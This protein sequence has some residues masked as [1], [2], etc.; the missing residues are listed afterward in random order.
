MSPS[1]VGADRAGAADL[2]SELGQRQRRTAGGPRSGD[3]DLLDELAALA[4]R[5]LLDRAHE[6]VENVD[7]HRH[8]PHAPFSSTGFV[9]P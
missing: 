8:D 7:A 3:P 1:R 5:D 4:L 9:V 6:D 2:R